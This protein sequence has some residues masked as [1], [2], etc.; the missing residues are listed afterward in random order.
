MWVGRASTARFRR[1]RAGPGETQRGFTGGI[2][3]WCRSSSQNSRSVIRSDQFPVTFS[4]RQQ[5]ALCERPTDWGVANESTASP[6]GA[7]E[8]DPLGPTQGD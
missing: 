7:F 4:P 3:H 6:N 1:C 8:G 5:C 2:V